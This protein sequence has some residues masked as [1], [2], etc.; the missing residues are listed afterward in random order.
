MSQEVRIA[1]WLK[2]GITFFG[3]IVHPKN[4]FRSFNT[5]NVYFE[6]LQTSFNPTRLLLPN[7]SKSLFKIMTDGVE[8]S[9][10]I[11]KS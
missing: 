7:I 8:L 1:I 11:I 3:N 6:Y 5:Y 4:I 9:A 2:K 10:L